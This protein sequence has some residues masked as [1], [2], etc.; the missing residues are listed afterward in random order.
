MNPLAILD[1][2]RTPAAKILGV[3]AMVAA[4][5]VAGCIQGEGNV[6]SKWN[7]E[8][9]ATAEAVASQSIAVADLSRKSQTINSEVSNYV[10]SRNSD[11]SARISGLRQPQSGHS[12]LPYV[13]RGTTGAA[14]CQP[15]CVPLEQF[16]DLIWEAGNTAVMVE[17]WQLWYQRQK[18]AFEAFEKSR[19]AGFDG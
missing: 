2:V 5:F 7:E 4:V 10:Q 16:N 8:K 17:G 1:L 9:A 15:G 6:K 19:S 18:D 14:T 11:L 13:A 12:A 3:A